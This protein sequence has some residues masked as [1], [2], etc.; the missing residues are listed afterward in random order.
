[1]KADEKIFGKSMV[2]YLVTNA[3]NN[4]KY[5]GQTQRVLEERIA[6]HRRSKTSVIYH[7]IQKYGW[8]NFAVEILDEC[9]TIDELNDREIYWI[10]KL[11]TKVPNG[12]NLTDGGVGT[13]GHTYTVDAR[14][15]A[16]KRVLSPE[17]V[18]H[19]SEVAPNRRT[20]MC[21][22]T[23]EIFISLAKAAAWAG[24][25]FSSISVA[26]NDETK[27]A[28]GYHWRLIG[29]PRMKSTNKK[30]AVL[31]IETNQVFDS[32]K[33]AARWAGV[34]KS[35]IRRVLSNKNLT[36]GG[37]H[38]KLLED[39]Y[40]DETSRFPKFRA[41]FCVETGE[42][43][44]TIKEAAAWAGIKGSSI[45]SVLAGRIKTAGRYHWLAAD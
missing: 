26:A 5:V 40:V 43:F 38:W 9:K 11:K 33:A 36:A 27:T 24:I 3:V 30:K 31:C 1:M 25:N 17:Q 14:Q 2:I 45:S 13:T 39:Y 32:I 6:E 7:A 37:Y 15:N 23:G 12:Y 41:V 19:M 21:V 44:Q 29:S 10:E 22:E 4:K 20:V 16:L 8:E 34:S 42:V 28:G 35:L 18:Q